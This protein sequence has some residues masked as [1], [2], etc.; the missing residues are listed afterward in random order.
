MS[1]KLQ[2]RFKGRV[3]MALNTARIH[4]DR[5]VQHDCQIRAQAYMNAMDDVKS[6]EE[7]NALVDLW[8]AVDELDKRGEIDGSKFERVHAV[9][10]KLEEIWTGKKR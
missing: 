2:Q 7:C 6:D 5:H 4:P 1:T 9:L 3:E 8:K 10:G